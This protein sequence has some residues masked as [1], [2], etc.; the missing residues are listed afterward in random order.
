MP[1]LL[2]LAFF[3]SIYAVEKVEKLEWELGISKKTVE[4]VPWETGKGFVKLE[5]E[6]HC[7]YGK[8]IG[9]SDVVINEAKSKKGQDLM[10][11]EVA[12][13]GEGK[14]VIRIKAPGSEKDSIASIT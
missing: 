8:I 12:V 1:I 4:L 14:A 5:I 7:Q 10:T 2:S 9:L 3:Q 11:D 6:P 13:C